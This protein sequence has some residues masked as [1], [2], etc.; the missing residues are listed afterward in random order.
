L[1]LPWGNVSVGLGA[2]QNGVMIQPNKVDSTASLNWDNLT[3]TDTFWSNPTDTP[4]VILNAGLTGGPAL[5]Y[6]YF[7][8][9]EME[10]VGGTNNVEEVI[11]QLE[12]FPNPV[13]EILNIELGGQRKPLDIRLMSVSGQQIDWLRFQGNPSIIKLDLTNLA[14]GIYIL[15]F[16]DMER[17]K[18][19]KVI[20]I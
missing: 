1:F 16:S 19:K 4:I 17:Y 15:E 3:V 13:A 7:D 14:A 2:L 5:G 11:H 10:E 8:L 12:I 9:V 6:A 18:P 20:K